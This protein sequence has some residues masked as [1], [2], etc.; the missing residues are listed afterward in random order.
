MSDNY[1]PGGTPPPQPQ[2]PN[3][4]N[5]AGGAY[6]NY[7][8]PA[9]PYPTTGGSGGGQLPPVVTQNA[10][11][12]KTGAITGALTWVAA[13]IIGIIA[14]IIM[15]ASSSG[16]FGGFGAAVGL[17]FLITG[18][19][20]GG[21]AHVS[22]SLGG[23]GDAGG[24]ASFTLLTGTILVGVA[25]YFIL[26]KLRK[27][28]PFGPLV[29]WAMTTAAMWLTLYLM[30]VILSL[31]GSLFMSNEYMSIRSGF[32]FAIFATLMLSVIVTGLYEIMR[33]KEGSTPLKLWLIRAR[34]AL[35]FLALTMLGSGVALAIVLLL[36]TAADNGS[37]GQAFVGGIVLLG[38]LIFAGPA[39]LVG[40]PL[41]F[42]ESSKSFGSLSAS[43]YSLA[44][45]WVTLIGLL[46]ALV[47]LGFLAY[48]V[49]KTLPPAP[50]VRTGVFAAVFAIA[51]IIALI[52]TSVSG[53]TS[54]S[55][56]RGLLPLT[57]GSAGM[58]FLTVFVYALWGAA[59][60]LVARFVIPLAMPKL[61]E[62]AATAKE[63]ARQANQPIPQTDG[64]AGAAGAAGQQSAAAPRPSPTHDWGSAPSAQQ[65][66]N[67]VPP[68]ELPE[69]PRATQPSEASQQG[70]APDW[71]TGIP[72]DPAPRADETRSFESVAEEPAP[73]PVTDE[74][75]G[76]SAGLGYPDSD[77]RDD[78]GGFA[79][80]PP[81]A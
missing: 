23:L 8:Q 1:S 30:H 53:G 57:S 55:E 36:G 38:H 56:L 10:D 46:L 77:K 21:G 75:Q 11:A 15:A 44:P 74:D 18:M 19:I 37:M 70:R 29:S 33:I 48:R 45:V 3:Q 63:K 13:F 66:E 42:S 26:K 50:F 58:S 61:K 9:S 64:S 71:G 25:A 52:F 60:D 69:P 79:P 7:Q 59:I 51:G 24:N 43:L 67:R 80:P 62:A 65:A 32:G 35:P 41:V 40:T 76:K 4:P 31:I 72:S 49:S 17:M 47:L 12:L 68:Q 54:G 28:K 5:P 27:D 78:R 34:E 6:P 22:S 20:F 2:Q 81:P 39:A 16:P 14:A 73:F